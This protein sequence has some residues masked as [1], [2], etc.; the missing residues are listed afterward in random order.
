MPCIFTIQNSDDN[1][2]KLWQQFLRFF[3]LTYPIGTIVTSSLQISSPINF[4]PNT[5]FTN[6]LFAPPPGGKKRNL[7]GI[8]A[9]DTAE[10]GYRRFHH[11]HLIIDIPG[12]KTSLRVFVQKKNN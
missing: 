9:Q 7:K 8:K 3:P 5:N 6:S 4:R 10:I 2:L 12:Q 1:D 11:N